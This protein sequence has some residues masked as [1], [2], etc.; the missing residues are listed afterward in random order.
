M[1]SFNWIDK[2][3]GIDDVLAEDINEIAHAVQEISSDIAET[4]SVLLSKADK[5]KK[6]YFPDV[7]TITLADNTNYVASDV[8]SNL[9]IIYPEGD[10]IAS[11]TFTLASEGA[12]TITLPESKYIGGAPTF[13]KGETWELNI[14]NGVVVGGLVE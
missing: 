9:T 6:E 1:V 2:Q 3:D 7:Q 11:L 12:I 4:S 8:I 13:A 5:P 10:F 14:K